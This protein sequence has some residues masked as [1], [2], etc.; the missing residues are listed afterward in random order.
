MEIGLNSFP[1]TP[2]RLM[3]D[4]VYEGWFIPAGTTVIANPWFVTR[5]YKPFNAVLLTM[6]KGCSP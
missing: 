3:E 6:V 4:D 2:H 1:G 5:V